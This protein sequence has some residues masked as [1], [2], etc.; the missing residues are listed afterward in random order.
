MTN[1]EVVNSAAMKLYDFFYFT[2]VL[3]SCE[4]Q[5]FLFYLEKLNFV[6]HRK[7]AYVNADAEM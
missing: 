3:V 1:F 5:L 7:T 6:L 2:V 4:L